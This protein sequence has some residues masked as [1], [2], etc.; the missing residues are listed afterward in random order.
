[1]GSFKTEGPTQTFYGT[2]LVTRH[3]VKPHQ[4]THIALQV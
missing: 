3:L 4:S 2:I 1:M